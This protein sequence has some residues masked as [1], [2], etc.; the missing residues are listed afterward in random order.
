MTCPIVGYRPAVINGQHVI[1]TL[2]AS[3]YEMLR[4]K[5]DPELLW[6]T[7]FHRTGS[8]RVNGRRDEIIA[9]WL[10]LRYPD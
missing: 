9:R 10:E 4:A 7:P 8:F 2:I 6:W 3:Q 5:G 1:I